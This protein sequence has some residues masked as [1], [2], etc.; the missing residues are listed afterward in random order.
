MKITKHKVGRFLVWTLIPTDKYEHELL[1]SDLR[2]LD[3]LHAVYTRPPNYEYGQ[4]E[5]SKP[6]L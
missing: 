3:E 2:H 6:I 5:I 4:I 1:A